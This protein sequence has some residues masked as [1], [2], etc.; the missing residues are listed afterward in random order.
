MKVLFLDIDGVLNTHEPLDPDVMCGRFHADKVVLLNH[1]LRNT[2][3]M[4]VLSS[5]WR[6]FIHRGE[7]NL[8][9]IDWL[10]RSHGV[11]RGRL[12]GVTR[13]DT[14]ER[15]RV[16]D[17]DTATW[18]MTNERGQQISDCIAI[19][20]GAF[21]QRIDR[22]A[23]VDD[24]DLGITEAGHPFVQVD[25]TIGLTAVHAERLIALLESINAR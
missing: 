5:A 13:V 1:V 4:I 14:M 24:M 2:G 19:A 8:A 15:P 10:L 16:Y 11:M 17:G 7:M 9:G 6:Y 25:G 21:G 20:I 3:A 12:A 23:V 22:Y 18:P